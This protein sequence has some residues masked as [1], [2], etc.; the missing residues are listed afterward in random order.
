M[1]D[2]GERGWTH[3]PCKGQLGGWPRCCPL[4]WDHS[5]ALPIVQGLS[6][7]ISYILSHFQVASRQENHSFVTVSLLIFS[8]LPYN[9]LRF[10]LMIKRGA[11]LILFWAHMEL[12]GQRMGRLLRFLVLLQNPPPPRPWHPHPHG[13]CALR[14]HIL[15]DRSYQ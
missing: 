10:S 2:P 7:V 11:F 8:K 4:I 15:T 6:T 5:P 3:F 1:Q 9:N 14:L 12:L 13:A